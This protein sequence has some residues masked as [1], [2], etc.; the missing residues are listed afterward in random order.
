[1]LTASLVVV[2]ALWLGWVF[3]LASMNLVDNRKELG[4]AGGPVR[5]QAMVDSGADLCLAFPDNKSIGTWDC[6]QRARA[7]D[8]ASRGAPR[9]PPAPFPSAASQPEMIDLAEPW[10][11]PTRA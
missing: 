8:G 5:N 4:K 1:M 11:G 7:A 9:N 3:Y 6:V 2:L 10:P